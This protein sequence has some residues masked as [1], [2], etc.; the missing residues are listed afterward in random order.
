M[1]RM[2]YWMFVLLLALM[3]QSMASQPASAHG[4]AY[5]VIDGNATITAEFFYSDNEPMRYAEVLVFGPGDE[6]VE[7]QNGRTDRMGRFA[8]FPQ[9]PGTWRI[10]VNDGVG[11]AVHTRF[12]VNR[13]GADG[14]G[15]KNTPV[16]RNSLLGETSLFTRIILGLSLML[17]L[18][19][20]VYVWKGVGISRK[21]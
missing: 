13:R 14:T 6:N 20:G 4:T 3:Y 2:I 12:E 7:Y 17:N 8:F 19:L 11:H 9:T 1:K 5:R 21:R 16:V 10:E 18:F 15:L